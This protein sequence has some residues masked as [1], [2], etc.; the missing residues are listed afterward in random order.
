MYSGNA[1]NNLRGKLPSKMPWVIPVNCEGCG[2]CVN[3]CKTGGLKMIKTNIDGVYVPWLIEPEK[4]SGCGRCSEACVM[5]A[6]SMTSYVEDAMFRFL[7]QKP[8]ILT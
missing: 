6:I 2:S 8:I 7:K 4:C 5:G 1:K 3:N